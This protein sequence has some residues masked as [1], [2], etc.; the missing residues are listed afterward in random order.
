MNRDKETIERR[1]N[2]IYA[3]FEELL[4]TGKQYQDLYCQIAYEFY[5]S[6]ATVKQI[7]LRAMYARS[8]NAR[9][10]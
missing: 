9:T 1:N 8:R 2:D 3:R 10:R 5:L 4:P 7:I 6:D